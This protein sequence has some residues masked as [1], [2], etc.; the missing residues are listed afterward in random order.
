LPALGK[1]PHRRAP[2]M[3]QRA[4]GGGN[5]ARGHAPPRRLDLRRIKREDRRPLALER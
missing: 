3:Q 1:R 4:H 2:V 5:I